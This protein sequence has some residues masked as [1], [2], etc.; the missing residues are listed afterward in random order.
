MRSLA[1]LAGLVLL[2]GCLAP[3]ASEDLDAAAAIA[4]A[5]ALAALEAGEPMAN[6]HL[7]G[8]WRNGNGA[9]LAAHGDLLYVMRAG[10]VQVLDVSDPAEIKE[11]AVIK[12]PHRVLDVKLSDDGRYL[13]IGDDAQWTLAATAG[14]GPFNGGVW[15]YD[16]EDPTDAKLVDY[17]PI[18]PRRG[19]HMVFYH[20]YPDGQEVVFGANAD[21]SI[22]VFDRAAGT[23][24]PAS[25]YQAD[26]VFAFNRQPMVFDVL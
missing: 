10:T 23:L 24:T 13:F 19:P 16:V 3:A 22:S 18:G 5:D 2:A 4:L 12:G 26:L 7:M 1:A 6:L 8:E 21:I 25:R 11:V 9:E 14:K 20:R 17:L 15:V